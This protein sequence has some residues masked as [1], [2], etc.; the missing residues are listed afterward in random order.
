MQITQTLIW[1]SYPWIPI[2]HT[3]GTLKAVIPKVS[4][5]GIFISWS[6]VHS[7]PW[8]GMNEVSQGTLKGSW[9]RELGLW[10]DVSYLVQ[11]TAFTPMSISK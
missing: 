6:G 5:S 7:E 2:G 4:L 1:G 11:R 9:G 3:W 10:E 8:D